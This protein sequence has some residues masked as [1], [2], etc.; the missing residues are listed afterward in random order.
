MEQESTDIFYVI[1]HDL[2]SMSL[3]G[4]DCTA[5]VSLFLR[6]AESGQTDQAIIS[7][8]SSSAFL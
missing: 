7:G 4:P 3:L 2:N 1:I 6:S 8:E 5:I